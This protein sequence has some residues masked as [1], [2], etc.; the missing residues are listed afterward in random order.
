[1]PNLLS[2]LSKKSIATTSN[3]N[4]IKYKASNA[5]I[6]SDVVETTLEQIVGVGVSS[7]IMGRASDPTSDYGK[8]TSWGAAITAG[9]VTRIATQ[10]LDEIVLQPHLG[11]VK[12]IIVGN[13]ETDEGR[14][15]IDDFQLEYLRDS[16]DSYF[17]TKTVLPYLSNLAVSS[18]NA[19]HGY[20]RHNNSPAWALGWFLATSSGL[21][22]LGLAYNQGF[23]KPIPEKAYMFRHNKNRFTN[24]R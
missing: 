1:M 6:T 5:S 23:A 11:H 22:N 19:Y 20:K 8:D 16:V 18:L 15:Q 13:P 3:P 7:A 24:S 21:S 2:G 10:I 14:K 9:I 4:A 17:E 12:E